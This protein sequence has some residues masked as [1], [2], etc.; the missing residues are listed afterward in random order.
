MRGIF[1][2]DNDA[3]VKTDLYEFTYKFIYVYDDHL[4]VFKTI[5]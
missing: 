5:Y 3:D 2:L 1:P 4:T